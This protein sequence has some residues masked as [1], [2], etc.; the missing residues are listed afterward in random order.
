MAGDG[1]SGLINVWEVSITAK[2]KNVVLVS[3]MEVSCGITEFL[4]V[5][6]F[7]TGGPVY[8]AN[9]D[10]FLEASTWEGRCYKLCVCVNVYFGG[11]NI[12]LDNNG[13]TPIWT[14]RPVAPCNK[15][16]VGWEY[17]TL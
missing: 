12:M 10:R 6:C 3:G 8:A 11:I 2:P 7:A 5:V 4:G 15:S 16:V 17:F 1:T 14:I 9:D 13:N